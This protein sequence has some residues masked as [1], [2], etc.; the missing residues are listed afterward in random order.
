MDNAQHQSEDMVPLSQLE[1]IVPQHQLEGKNNLLNR[2][3]SKW[4]LILYSRQ[5]RIKLNVTSSLLSLM[6]KS[7]RFH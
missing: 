6:R 4:L 5:L 7:V 2:L 3:V 1:D